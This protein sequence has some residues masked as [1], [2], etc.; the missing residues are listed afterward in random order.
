MEILLSSVGAIDCFFWSERS[1]RRLFSK[2]GAF[3]KFPFFEGVDSKIYNFWRRGSLEK[4]K[5]KLPVNFSHDWSIV[6]AFLKIFLK[7]FLKSECGKRVWKWKNSKTCATKKAENNSRLLLF[8][9]LFLLGSYWL[10][11]SIILEKSSNL[12]AAPPIK[13][14]SISGWEKISLALSGFTEPP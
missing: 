10:K 12:R 8:T 7:K 1:E 14:P 3:T 2:F 9:W 5:E 4:W 6:W 13:P 11:P